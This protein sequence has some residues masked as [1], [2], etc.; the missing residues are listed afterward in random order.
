MAG[1]EGSA[2][3]LAPDCAELPQLRYDAAEADFPQLVAA[4]EKLR[5][6][7]NQDA[8]IQLYRG[9]IALH[10]AGHKHSFAA[11]FNL[12][13]ELGH[14]GDAAGAMQAYQAALALRPDFAAAAINYG[15][16]MERAGDINAALAAWAAATQNDEARTSLI[17]HRARLLERGGELQQAE[18]LLFTSLLTLPAQPDVIQHWVHVRQK[19]C[20]WPALAELVPGLPMAQMVS[21]CGP[22]AALALFER[23]D[24]QTAIAAAWIARKTNAVAE[25]L[26]PA[27]GYA[28]RRLRIAYLSS[29]FCRHAMSFL[30][31]ELF[32]RHDRAHF[33]IYG[34]C[35]TI[36][37]HSDIRARVLAAFDHTRF[38][39]GLSDEAAARLIRADEIDILIDLNGL[40]QGAR[41]Q[42]LRWRP[43]PVQATY[44]GFIGPVPLPELDYLFCDDFVIPPALAHAYQ[45]RPLAI[46]PNYQAN[47][48]KRTPGPPTTRARAGLPAS[49]F[50]F[51]CFSNHYKIT[52]D[53]FIAW[54]KI[55]AGVEH[56][57]LWLTADSKWSCENLRDYAT[58]SGIDPGRLIFAGRVSPADY[59]ARLAVADLFLDTFPYNAG[60]IASDAIRMGLPLLTQMGE[61]YASRM[62]ARLLDA[63]GA[64][65][66]ITTTREAYVE[67][68]VALATGADAYRDYKALFT[69]ARWAET[70]GDIGLLTREL[71]ATLGRIAKC[72]PDPTMVRCAAVT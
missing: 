39:R 44:L 58:K 60:T 53:M 12:G 30:I 19:M 45:P 71:E 14:A 54:M 47:D 16:Q 62:A 56:S 34:Y 40:T 18:R 29:D 17:N 64:T 51:C 66:G 6:D 38:V 13:A 43:A 25:R 32:E 4:A 57:F 3:R 7:R 36:D 24:A 42:I 48:S 68:A 22:L 9:W 11:W 72:R 5:A 15:L 1:F 2:E 20:L 23:V 8:V 65:A 61:S 27:E 41:L 69:E 50:V 49:G 35:S 46:A 37:D 31:A 59:M 52:E 55:L 26:S 10:A 63:I 28:H 33:E 70:L 21:C 67:M